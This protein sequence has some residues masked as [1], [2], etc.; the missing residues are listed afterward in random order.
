[1]KKIICLLLFL[2]GITT[3]SLGQ[4]P[5]YAM[6]NAINAGS[7]SASGSFTDTKS[8]VAGSGYTNNYGQASND[9]WYSFTIGAATNMVTLSLCSSSF[10]TYLHLLN[11]SGTEIAFNDDDVT[12]LACGGLAS[13]MKMS[14]LAP[15]TYYVDAEGYSTNTGTIAFS[16]N[17]SI[18]TPLSVSYAGPQTY[19]VG[20]A[21]TSLTPTISGNTVSAPGETATFAGTGSVGSADGNGTS[22]S[23]NQPLG[24]TVDPSGN[25]FIAEAG[26][27]IIR[28][29]TPAGQVSIFAGNYSQGFVNNTTGTSASFYHPVGLASDAS[30]NIYVA[31]EDNNVIR[32]ITPGGAVSTFAGNGSQGIN[33][34]TVTAASATFKYPCGVAVDGSGNVYVA[35]SYN[36]LIRKISGGMVSIF[37]GNVSGTAG[38]ADGQGT[39]ASFNQPF[40]VVTDAAGNVYVTDRVGAKIRKITPSGLVSTLAG[41]GT[42]GYLDA[43][44]GTTAQFNAP[45]GLA[46][47]KAGNLYVTD[48]SNN[49][50]RKV[51]PAGAVTTLS[52]TGAQGSANGAGTA[53]TFNLPFAI[54]AD[55]GGLVYAGDFTTNLIRKI[56]ATPFTVSPA[57]P[58]GLSLNSTTGVISGTPTVVTAQADYTIKANNTF[59]TA[60]AQLTMKVNN[61]GALNLSQDQNYIATYIPSI[62]ALTTDALVI[63]ASSD[64]TKEQVAVQYFDGLGRPLQSVQ[65][66]GGATGLKDIVQPVEYD[67]YGREAKKYLPY[68]SPTANGSYKANAISSEMGSFYNPGGNGTSGAQQTN[69]SGIVVNPYPFSLTNFE[70]SPLNRV[71]EQGAPGETW[72]PGLRAVTPTP[73]G[74]TIL[75]EYT[76]NDQVAF[77]NTLTGN[78]GSR[79]VA[80]YSVDASGNLSR[81]TLESEYY[82][83]GKLFVTITRDENWNTDDGCFG[84]AEEYKNLEGLVILKRTYNRGTVGEMLSTYYVYDKLNNLCFVLPPGSMPDDLKPVN[85]YFHN[86]CYQYRYD[87][88]Q[89]LV[90]KRVPGKGW[91][92]MIYNKLD[93]VVLTQDAVQR[94]R[95]PQEWT[96]TKYDK[97]GRVVITAIYQDAGSAADAN[98]NTPALTRLTALQSSVTNQAGLL[99]E[100]R[101]GALYHGYTIN[102]F[103]ASWQT[104]LQINYYDTYDNIPGKPG[105]FTTPA[106]A[107]TQTK[108]LL[109]CTRTN[110]LGITGDYSQLYTVNYYDKFGRLTTG[111]SQHYFGG[112][113]SI[114]NYDMV[115]NT[116]SFTSQLTNSVRTHN[117]KNAG[118]TAAVIKAT[119]GNEYIYDHMGRK[120]KSWQTLT[121]T[122]RTLLNNVVYNELGQLWTKY[123]HTTDTVANNF[124]QQ[125]EYAYNERGWLKRINDPSLTPTAAKVFG[126]ELFYNDGANKEFNGNIGNVDWRTKVPAG[127][128]LNDQLQKYAYK[129]DDLNRLTQGKYNTGLTNADKYNEDLTYDR[130]GNISALTR[131]D[132]PAAGVYL[133]NIG[134]N[135][136][137]SGLGNKLWKT[138]EG[139]NTYTY[140]YDLNGNAISDSR[141]LVTGITYNVLNLPQTVTRTTGNLVYTYDAAGRKLRKTAGGITRE[142]IGGIEY[143]GTEIEFIATEEGRAL[144]APSA[145]YSYEYYLKDHLGNTRAAIKQDQS[146]VQVQDYYPFGKGIANL[147]TSSPGN[148]YKYNGKEEQETGQYDYGARFYDPVIARWTSVDPLAEQGRRWSPYVYGFDNPI[149]FEDPDGM[150]PSPIMP[151]WM[152]SAVRSVATWMGYVGNKSSSLRKEYTN[153]ASALTER[154]AEN[155]IKRAELKAE[156]REATPQP[157]RAHLDQIRPMDAEKAKAAEGVVN[158]PAKTNEKFNQ[159]GENLGTVGKVATGVAV[160]VSVYNIATSDNKP[161][162]VVEEAGG[163]AGAWAGGVAGAEGGAGVGAVVGLGVFD[164]VTIPVGSLLGGIG[165]SIWGGI[166]GKN[167]GTAAYD[168]ATQKKEPEKPKDNK[169]Q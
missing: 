100:V 110:V 16:L 133:N 30:G 69:G 137:M 27:H 107:S 29:I 88:R 72:Q 112:V 9:V 124:K 31:D 132:N 2:A 43:S 165:G 113:F 146:I 56:V 144:Y 125:T 54:A 121:G 80:N 71:T 167:V 96:M 134:Y 20:T 79:Q 147:F 63:S 83:P 143:N 75:M 58:A 152:L 48:E 103:P 55:A 40:S 66:K 99:W 127:F 140:T 98:A 1:M 123:L 135:Y 157:V 161:K 101:G 46:I 158:N 90:Q 138:T 102:A 151:T 77:S 18:I 5:G 53:S 8:N 64:K 47:D 59:N 15:G 118:N 4:V 169:Q 3:R 49:R 32:M 74:R 36:N 117:I 109:T 122:P 89:R 24:A 85:D 139:S 168:A 76:T 120:L 129:Y 164:E 95:A 17:V 68:A 35:D 159:L 92:F 166:H 148:K 149:K 25:I 104:S 91:E 119:I 42:A 155:R 142:Y 141:N 145:P 87:E 108:G 39:A 6:S 136:D 114:Y 153:R 65:V 33:T 73:A 28:K 162:A 105:T 163:W 11:S 13:V 57:L 51:T 60:S 52:G 128:G 21:I 86:F 154:T 10:D 106:G 94:N 44:S 19:N 97:F 126:M 7:Y 131:K 82:A 67:A 45:T 61:A 70:P 38:T 78:P 37:A 150:W 41:S 22:A 111:Y 116:Y 34:G 156:I 130:M 26:S 14:N 50:I 23:F 160:G 115:V 81:A 84:T 12:G 93:Q 62:P